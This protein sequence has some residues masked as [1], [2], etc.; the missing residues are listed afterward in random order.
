MLDCDPACCGAIPSCL[1]DAASTV[2]GSG[3]CAGA[4]CAGGPLKITVAAA[5]GVPTIVRTPDRPGVDPACAAACPMGG[6]VYGLGLEYPGSEMP[7]MV[8]VGPPWELFIGFNNTLYCPFFDAGKGGSTPVKTSCLS[9][10]FVN[11]E[12]IFVMTKDPNAPARDISITFGQSTTCP[13]D[14]GV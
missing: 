5:D 11:D 1:E 6:Y 10:T 8:T 2:V 14:G 7:I 4:T 3:S 13:A 12:I 9:E